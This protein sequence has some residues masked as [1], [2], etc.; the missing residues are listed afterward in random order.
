MSSAEEEHNKQVSTA[1]QEWNVLF[2]L[3]FFRG[4][5]VVERHEIFMDINMTFSGLGPAKCGVLMLSHLF[6]SRLDV[7]AI[8]AAGAQCSH[9]DY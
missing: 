2:F 5:G 8:S 7:P 3:S 1:Q 6:V 9:K 4:R